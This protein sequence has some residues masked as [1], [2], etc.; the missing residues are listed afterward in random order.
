M[1]VEKD[2]YQDKI[3]IGEHTDSCL[4][5]WPLKLWN[6][7]THKCA[8]YEKFATSDVSEHAMFSDLLK[9]KCAMSQGISGR[10]CPRFIL[11][12]D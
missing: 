6:T 3:A 11:R 5:A 12:V 10:V 1:A 9:S 4:E 8:N 2:R 7:S